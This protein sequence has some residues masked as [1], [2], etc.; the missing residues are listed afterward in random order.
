[1]ACNLEFVGFVCSQI[2]DAGEVRSR[3]MFGDYVIYVNEKPVVILQGEQD[4]KIRIE[5]I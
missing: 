1:M 3:E 2:A 5:V 4:C